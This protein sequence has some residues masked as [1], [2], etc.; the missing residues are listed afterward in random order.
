MEDLHIGLASVEGEQ[1]LMHKKRHVNIRLAFDEGY[2]GKE[3]FLI[4][5]SLVDETQDVKQDLLTLVERLNEVVMKNV[6]GR[7]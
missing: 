6:W 5:T 2:L 4:T 7:R 1:I 3:S